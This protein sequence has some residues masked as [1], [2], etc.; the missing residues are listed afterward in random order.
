VNNV[1]PISHRGD[2]VFG[3]VPRAQC[4]EQSITNTQTVRAAAAVA[5]ASHPEPFLWLLHWFY[6]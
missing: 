1:S 2:Q 6:E 4:C 3:T 5:L